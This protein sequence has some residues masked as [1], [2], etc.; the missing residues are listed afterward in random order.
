[1]RRRFNCA[2]SWATKIR[3]ISFALLLGNMLFNPAVAQTLYD[4]YQV[5]KTSFGHPDLGGFWTNVSLTP[6]SRPR[7]LGDRLVYTEQ[8]VAEL[9]G[10][11]DVEEAEA[12][13]RTDPD[14]PAE[15]RHESTVV[16]AEFQAAGGAVGGYNRFWL[17]PGDSVMRVAGEPRTSLLTTPDGRIPPRK[18]GAA[19]ARRFSR[20]PPGTGAYDS[21]EVRSLGERCI[22]GF[23]RN[24]GP[25]MFANGFYNNNYQFVQGPEHVMIL[26][27]MNHDARI[28]RLN[29]KHR[30]DD[31]RPWFG[32][33]IGWWEGDTL[34][35]ET[36]HIPP[37]LAYYGSWEN[38]TVTERFTRVADERLHYAFTINDPSLWDQ[39]WGGEYEFSRL[40]GQIYEYACHEGNYALEG[41]LKGARIQEQEA[42]A[43]E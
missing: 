12:N 27:E 38:L 28:I 1:M 3:V 40:D 20:R 17:N 16:R 30:E 24:A 26:V 11:V 2:P 8:E 5:P 14:A 13:Q 39:P 18:D 36:T 15:F 33:S 37:T 31:V 25:P 7:D 43:T 6:L 35:V 19:P 42:Q 10:R 9:E 34:V 41:I 23:G 21:Y 22:I 29:S 32:D 4:N